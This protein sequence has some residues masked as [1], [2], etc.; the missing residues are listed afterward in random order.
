MDQRDGRGYAV[1]SAHHGD[2][3]ITYAQHEQHAGE[4]LP[5]PV[6]GWLV[7]RVPLHERCSVPGGHLRVRGLAKWSPGELSGPGHQHS[8]RFERGQFAELLRQ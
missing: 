8:D 4:G 6:S 2:D 7:E 5:V 3:H 1:H